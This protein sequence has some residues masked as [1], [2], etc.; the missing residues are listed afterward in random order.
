MRRLLL[1]GFIAC[2][3][4]CS[5]GRSDAL[6]ESRIHAIL[7]RGIASFRESG[8]LFLFRVEDVGMDDP[9]CLLLLCPEI[10]IFARGRGIYTDFR[11]YFDNLEAEFTYEFG[12]RRRI[13]IT[14]VLLD[15]DGKPGLRATGLPGSGICDSDGLASPEG[16]NPCYANLSPG[17]KATFVIDEPLMLQIGDDKPCARRQ[18]VD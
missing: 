3:L 13:P 4:G 11:I 2:T 9:D 10:I 17:Q 5:I 14:G 8:S 7:L 15:E 16:R 6:S 1:I 18:G 12:E